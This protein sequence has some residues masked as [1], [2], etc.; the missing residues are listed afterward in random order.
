ML[1]LL[2]HGDHLAV[3]VKLHDAKAL[4]VVDVIAEDG[5]AALLG[6]GHRLPQNAGETVA[7]EDVIPQHHGAHV[8]PDEFLADHKRL[9]Q[10]IRGG[11]HRVLQVQSKLAAVPQQRL[12]AR[13]IRGGGNNQDILNPRQ[14][15]RGQ[16]VVNHGLVI[17]GQQL[18]AGYH[19]QR[20]QPG[21]RAAGQNNSLHGNTS[22][23]GQYLS[24]YSMDTP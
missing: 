23:L 20:V 6:V 7:V 22:F 12:K 21:T 9:G 15:Q 24:Y 2:L 14:H 17:H 1:G 18:F 8:V 3:F 13:G 11:L 19:G 5:G 16:G 10:A 4:G